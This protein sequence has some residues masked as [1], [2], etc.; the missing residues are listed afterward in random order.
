ME[1]GKCSVCSKSGALRCGKCRAQYYCSKEC[2][3]KDWKIHK[4]VC[5]DV[6]ET[7][8]FKKFLDPYKDAEPLNETVQELSALSVVPLAERHIIPKYHFE[9]QKLYPRD[10]AYYRKLRNMWVTFTSQTETSIKKNLKE[11]V[12]DETALDKRWGPA[13]STK[14]LRMF[15]A[16]KPKPGDIFADKPHF[17]HGFFFNKDLYETMKNSP[18]PPQTFELG[19]KYVAVGF[20]DMFPL[21]VGSFVPNSKDPSQQEPMIYFGYDRSEIVVAKNMILYYMMASDMPLDSILQVW[22]STGW[23]EETLSKFQLTCK[24]LLRAEVIIPSDPSPDSPWRK[25]RA[26]IQHWLDTTLSMKSVQILWSQHINQSMH[27]LLNLRYEIDRVEYARYL[28]TGHLFGKDDHDYKYGNVTMFSLPDEYQNMKRHAENFFN[29]IAVDSLKY[30]TSLMVSV[31]Q[32]LKTG[33]RTVIDLIQNESL[34]CMFLPVCICPREDR[35]IFK[36]IRNMNPKRIDWSNIPD[37]SNLDEFFWLAKKCSGPD[38]VHLLHFAN[39]ISYV[40]GTALLDYPKKFEMYRKL[41]AQRNKEY[42]HVK[43]KRPFLRQDEY[44][45]WYLNSAEATL[46]LKYRNNFIDFV[47]NGRNLDVT[48]PI[49]ERFNPFQRSEFIFFIS[50]TFRK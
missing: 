37:Y 32:K 21:L 7:S 30:E 45:E 50:F 33:L 1:D 31:T 25:V 41:T 26:L 9:Y 43:G 47:F 42:S 23:N 6:R 16:N 40:Y 34:K 27:A 48:E 20:V 2:Q 35:K 14:E 38:T 3:I 36:E 29:T 22:F 18:T 12:A 11:H 44:I 17:P 39:W 15:L 5:A 46:A 8:V 4:K 10:E 49:H 24:V 28:S 19:E 13:A